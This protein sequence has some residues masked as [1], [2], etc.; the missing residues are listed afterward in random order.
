MEKERVEK[1]P[2]ELFYAMVIGWLLVI[3]LSLYMLLRIK[4][5]D[6]E[7]ALF[8][9]SAIFLAFT[10]W[11]IIVVEITRV[12]ESNHLYSLRKAASK[13]RGE[14]ADF[15]IARNKIAWFRKLPIPEDGPTSEIIASYTFKQ[16]QIISFPTPISN[17]HYW[18][19]VAVIFSLAGIGGIIAVVLG[20]T[21]DES[22]YL[23]AGVTYITAALLG[24]RICT[25]LK[26]LRPIEEETLL[27]LK[28]SLG[29]A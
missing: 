7:T 21:G 8:I 26:K 13:G 16:R 1:R 10:I 3:G 15:I 20:L 29:T 9:F 14:L 6:L 11:G 22:M 19:A 2:K 28:D 5:D 17:K 27:A 12:L 25:T 18:E 4:P 23:V 24:L